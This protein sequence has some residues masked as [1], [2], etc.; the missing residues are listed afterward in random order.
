MAIRLGD[1]PAYERLHAAEEISSVV[2]V[3][4]GHDQG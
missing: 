2:V 3:A 4:G 1:P